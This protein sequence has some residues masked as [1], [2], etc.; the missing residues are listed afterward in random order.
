MIRTYGTISLIF[1]QKSETKKLKLARSSQEPFILCKEPI[2]TLGVDLGVGSV[3]VHPNT[4]LWGHCSP[5]LC[6]PVN[7]TQTL[8]DVHCVS[9]KRDPDII[10]C[11]F[12][13]D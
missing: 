2:K 5:P 1:F 10:D 3:H 6:G 7:R 12:K 13:K 11:N 4:F 8:I 9:I